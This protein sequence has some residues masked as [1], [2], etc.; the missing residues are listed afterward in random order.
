VNIIYTLIN[1]KN[2]DFD[3]LVKIRANEWQEF[4]EETNNIGLA[5]SSKDI[6][7]IQNVIKNRSIYSKVRTGRNTYTHSIVFSSL[8]LRSFV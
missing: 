2:H 3:A 8:L 6:T 4:S 1:L 5:L 7:F